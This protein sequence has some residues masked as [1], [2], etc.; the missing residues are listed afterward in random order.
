MVQY[1]MICNALLYWLYVIIFDNETQHKYFTN[2]H[3][4]IIYIHT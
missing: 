4:H 1:V 2:A 3:T